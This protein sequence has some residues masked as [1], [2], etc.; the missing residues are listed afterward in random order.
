MLT[1][2]PDLPTE[3]KEWIEQEIVQR[4]DPHRRRAI[5]VKYPILKKPLMSLRRWMQY[6]KWRFSRS[7]YARRGEHQTALPWV[8]KKHSSVLRRKL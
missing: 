1:T 7:R 4:T 5:S 6:V 2:Y 3:I 8:L